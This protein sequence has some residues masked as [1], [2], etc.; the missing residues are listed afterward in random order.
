MTDLSLLKTVKVG[1]GSQSA[2][3]MSAGRGCAPTVTQLGSDA[4][5]GGPLSAEVKDTTAISLHGVC[6]IEHYRDSFTNP[7][8]KGPSDEVRSDF[9]Q[10]STVSRAGK[11]SRS[12]HVHV[13]YI[14]NF[15]TE[16][17]L[18]LEECSGSV[19]SADTN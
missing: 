7:T 4:D 14:F 6:L 8:G 5:N 16:M 18:V 19:A 17:C 10:S 15:T 9:S 11:L 3:H 12:A 13:C 2:S 1:S